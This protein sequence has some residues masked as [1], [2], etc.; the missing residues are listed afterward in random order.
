MIRGGV[1]KRGFK[2]QYDH[3]A[4]S[5]GFFSWS[6]NRQNMGHKWKK[7]LLDAH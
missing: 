3:I 2:V 6:I 1:K 5:E 7:I 4:S